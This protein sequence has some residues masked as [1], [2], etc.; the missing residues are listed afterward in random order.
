MLSALNFPTVASRYFFRF[1]ELSK[2][3]YF[4]DDTLFWREGQGKWQK[5]AA[6]PQLAE[7]LKTATAPIKPAQKSTAGVVAATATTAAAALLDPLTG[8][9]S[10]IKSLEEDLD[11]PESPPD[12]EKRFI[13]DDG[14]AYEWN[15]QQ[16]KFVPVEGDNDGNNEENTAA[17]AAAADADAASALQATYT[18]ADMVYDP[19]H[20]K[21]PSFQ[22]PPEK[23]K[24]EAEDGDLEEEQIQNIEAKAQIAGDDEEGNAVATE[25]PSGKRTARDAALEAAKERAKKAKAHRESQ[26]GW[27]D[28][29]KNTSVYVTG[30]PGDVTVAE[31]AETFTKCGII[32]E[33]P[34]TRHPRIKLYKDNATGM[35]KGDALVTFL[36]EPSVDLAINLLDKA[37]FRYGLKPMTVSIAKFEQKGDKYV[38]KATAAQ[39]RKK[40]KVL[41]AQEKR[42]LGWKGFDDVVKSTDVT[43]V[44]KGMFIPEELEASP[45]AKDE[46]EADVLSEANKAGKVEKIRIFNKNPEG[47]VTVRYTT[48][49]EADACVVMMDG[50][51]FGSR[52]IQAAKY[53]G[54]TNFN[55]KVPV[56]EMEE[57][58]MA[59]LEAFAAEIEGGD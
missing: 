49:E 22:I 29:K 42:A 31:V 46:L 43:V 58:Q 6:L 13:D 12:D 19:D 1:A 55:V 2:A 23:R 3:S 4:N 40:K 33:D 44:L 34:E 24:N 18:D 28:L 36:K 47:I 9:F 15:S 21:L 10:E 54:V 14:T 52:Q 39:K 25:N 53:D 41:E 27:F 7:A 11:V 37:P 5:L 48:K 38:E 26:Q 57:E 51:W 56:V 8:F 17:I 30:L 35:L 45:T 20:E 32:K 59:R 50:R 16:R